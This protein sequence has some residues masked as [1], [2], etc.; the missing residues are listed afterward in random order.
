MSDGHGVEGEGANGNSP[1][2][3]KKVPKRIEASIR[4]VMSPTI[5]C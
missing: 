1:Q 2:K 5:N 3:K 4:G